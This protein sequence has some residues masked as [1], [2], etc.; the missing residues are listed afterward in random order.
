MPM[1]HGPYRIES[2][3]PTGVVAVKVYFP[4][5]GS[6]QVDAQRMT[7]CPPPPNFSY[8]YYWYGNRTKGPGRAPKQIDQMMKDADASS[9]TT[10]SDETGHVE[11]EKGGTSESVLNATP[12]KTWT[13]TVVPP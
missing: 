12:T 3:S 5:E 2:V 9:S 8:G 7:K 11:E 10:D 13:Q 1:W 4:Q 6:I